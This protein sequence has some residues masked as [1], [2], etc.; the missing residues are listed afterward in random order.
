MKKQIMIFSKK[1][2]KAPDTDVNPYMID[3]ASFE[4]GTM[5]GGSSVK[6]LKGKESVVSYAKV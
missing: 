3:D 4:I 1:K 5:K 6:A 2:S